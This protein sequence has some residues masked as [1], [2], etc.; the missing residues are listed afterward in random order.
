MEDAWLGEGGSLDF[1]AGVFR[2]VA[3]GCGNARSSLFTPDA[4]VSHARLVFCCEWEQHHYQ[5]ITISFSLSHLAQFPQLI[6]ASSLPP[7]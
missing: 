4:G 7:S 3:L 1:I 5:S 2:H 6:T